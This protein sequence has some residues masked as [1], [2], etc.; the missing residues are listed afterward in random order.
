MPPPYIF[1]FLEHQLKVGI[2][3]SNTNVFLYL[4][5]RHISVEWNHL[6]PDMAAI[7]DAAAFKNAASNLLLSAVF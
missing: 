1:C 4:L 5:I 2:I 6:P 3:S 7:H